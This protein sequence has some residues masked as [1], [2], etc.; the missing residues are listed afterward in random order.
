MAVIFTKGREGGEISLTSSDNTSYLKG[1][2]FTRRQAKI[3]SL[4]GR[5]RSG[6]LL[7][8][9]SKTRDWPLNSE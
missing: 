5:Q 3:S 2:D 4:E 8:A 7:R 6:A 1:L 9:R